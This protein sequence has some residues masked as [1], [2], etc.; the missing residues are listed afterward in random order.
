MNRA[1]PPI[2]MLMPTLQQADLWRESGRYDDYGKEMLRITRTGMTG[3]MLYGPTIDTESLTCS[4]LCQKLTS[5][6]PLNLFTSNGSSRRS[7]SAV[8][9]ECAP[10]NS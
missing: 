2:E 6:W 3:T 10:A 7:A 9:R 4:F 5:S 1:V 8:R